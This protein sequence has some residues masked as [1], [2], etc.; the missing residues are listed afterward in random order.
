[1]AIDAT[2]KHAAESNEG[3]IKKYFFESPTPL[4]SKGACP[5]TFN[6]F[7]TKWRKSKLLGNLDSKAVLKL[8]GLGG[9]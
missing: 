8:V 6:R 5:L 2:S 4:H 3:Q 9:L 7:K 1:M